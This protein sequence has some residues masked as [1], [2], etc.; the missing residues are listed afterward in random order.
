MQH[1]LKY[2]EELREYSMRVSDYYLKHGD[3]QRSAHAAKKANLIQDFLQ[4]KLAQCDG[5]PNL[6]EFS[7]HQELIDL[8]TDEVL[9]HGI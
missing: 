5:A 2:I 1:N 8:L 3:T 9:M 6:D 4:Q 7:I